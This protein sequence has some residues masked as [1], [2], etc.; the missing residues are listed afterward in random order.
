MPERG[1]L[2]QRQLFSNS[3][4]VAGWKFFVASPT[5]GPT[6]GLRRIP[7]A[8]YD[9]RVVWF[10]RM[11]TLRG[12]PRDFVGERLVGMDGLQTGSVAKSVNVL[13]V[14]GPS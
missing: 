5:P 8:A 13:S 10:E 1:V 11:L 9:A 14:E 3:L 7:L 12:S 2:R 6:A 4:M